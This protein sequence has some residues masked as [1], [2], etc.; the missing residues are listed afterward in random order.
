MLRMVPL[1]TAFGNRE[2]RK[3]QRNLAIVRPSSFA[4][5]LIDSSLRLSALAIVFSAMPL[6]A[7]LWSF[8]ISSLVQGCRCRSNLSAIIRPLA[9]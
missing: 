4:R 2:D 6:R 8:W 3:A 7:R 1:P 5:S 9:A